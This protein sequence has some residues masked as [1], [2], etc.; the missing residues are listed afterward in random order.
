MLYVLYQN[1][2]VYTYESEHKGM[3]TVTGLGLSITRAAAAGQM[4]T[5][6]TLL[7]TVSRNFITKLRET[8]CSKYIPL[9]SSLAFHKFVAY[10]AVIFSGKNHH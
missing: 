4:F 9:D 3:R 7:I 10:L 6:S 5:F 1:F 2:L 8:I